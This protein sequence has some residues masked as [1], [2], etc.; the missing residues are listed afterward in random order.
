MKEWPTS[1]GIFYAFPFSP[2]LIFLLQWLIFYWQLP[3]VQNILRK[4][5]QDGQI[6][7]WR[8]G[9]A[10]CSRRQFCW[11]FHSNVWVFL[12]IFHWLHWADHSDLGIIEKI[13]SSFR[14]WVQMMP[15]LVK[16][17]DVRSETKVNAPHGR[18]KMI[19]ESTGYKMSK[20]HWLY[21]GFINVSSQAGQARHIIELSL[22]FGYKNSPPAGQTR[23]EK[24]QGRI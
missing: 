6:L 2:F 17:D 4:Y 21:R 1:L 13:F 3:P 24:S 19:Q 8:N 16:G 9:E 5:H 12:W 11:V 22:N 10:R 18:L 23:R 15:I 20:L 7:L 14:T